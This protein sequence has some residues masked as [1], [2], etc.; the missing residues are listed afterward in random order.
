MEIREVEDLARKLDRRYSAGYGSRDRAM[1]EFGYEHEE[2]L[3]RLVEHGY[4]LTDLAEK[5]RISLPVA[6]YA[7]LIREGM[8]AAFYERN[9]SQF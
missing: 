7:D 5:A 4:S 2:D 9:G 1:R 3:R 8:G 6:Y